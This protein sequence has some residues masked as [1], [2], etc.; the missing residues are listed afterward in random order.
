MTSDTICHGVCRSCSH[1][2]ILFLPGRICEKCI[3]KAMKV[4]EQMSAQAL[5][6]AL[7]AELGEEADDE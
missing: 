1:R 5:L 6:E 7:E 4:A 3:E 2:R